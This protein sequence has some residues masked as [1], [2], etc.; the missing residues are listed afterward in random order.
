MTMEPIVFVRHEQ[1][2]RELLVLKLGESKI[3]GTFI[4]A[5]RHWFSNNRERRYLAMTLRG[6]GLTEG[7]AEVCLGDAFVYGFLRTAL[8]DASNYGAVWL[9]LATFV[10]T[11]LRS[12]YEC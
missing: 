8:D 3:R 7:F 5:S 11:Y 12:G 1:R 2:K 9:F 10:L 4:S 6:A